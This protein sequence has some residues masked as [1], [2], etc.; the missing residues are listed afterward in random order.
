MPILTA[1]LGS[2]NRQEDDISQTNTSKKQTEKSFDG[3]NDVRSSKE[4]GKYPNQ[5]VIKTRS[6]HNVVYDDTKGNESITI[7]HRGGSAIQFLPN[8]AVQ[9]TAH[10]GKY[11]IVF[12][13]NRMTVTGAHD[14]A[15]KGDGSLLV[16]G[17]YRKTVHG[18]IEIAAT[19]SI[20]YRGKNIVHTASENYSVVSQTNTQKASDSFG[21][22]SNQHASIVADNTT[23][24]GMN[25]VSMGGKT[26][27]IEGTELASIKSS[28]GN[29]DVYSK[30][31]FN[32]KV[33]GGD[34]TL[35]F[36]QNYTKTVGGDRNTTIAGSDSSKT[37]GDRT[38][39]V[40]GRYFK[41]AAEIHMNGQP[42]NQAIS[43]PVQLSLF[44]VGKLSHGTGQQKTTTVL[45]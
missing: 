3:P 26:A 27:A 20:A 44:E 12:G 10:N 33:E 7:Q 32:H 43:A 1:N 14:L 31:G 37:T 5:Q 39:S 19:G 18:D 13:E 4:A 24:I 6:G 38:V 41:T 17:N 22:F 36:A 9:M 40:T 15:V 16:Y 8:G 34:V 2:I 25:H 30:T 35:E 28:E 21:I 23:L 29:M 45:A 11:D 42:G